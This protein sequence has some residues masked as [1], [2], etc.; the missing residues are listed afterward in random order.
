MSRSIAFPFLVLPDEAIKCSGWRIAAG[1]SEPRSCEATLE[2]WDYSTAIHAEI[3]ID[4][5][6]SAVTQCLCL[7][8]S[9]FELTAVVW[10]STGPGAL[11]LRHLGQRVSMKVGHSLNLGVKILGH[12]LSAKVRLELELFCSIEG[13][14]P[15]PLAP[16]LT[17]A[18]VWTCQSEVLLEGG[19]AS[20]F[21]L[22]ARSFREAFNNQPSRLAPWHL[23]WQSGVPDADFSSAVRLWVNAD[24]PQFMERFMAGDP[25]TVQAVLGDVKEQ[26]VAST[27]DSED[28][29]LDGDYGDGSVGAQVRYWI[30]SAFPGLDLDQ[31]R[32]LM[33]QDRG[34]FCSALLATAA[35]GEGT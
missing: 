2:G 18:R 31:I 8:Q 23:F 34:K 20:R 3:D 13:L 27:L 12:Q 25:L 14:S 35:Q 6:W 10:W 24:M 11:P 15:H 1:E 30:E 19:G 32:N 16:N 29:A 21:P 7:N 17:M 33:L 22:E 9:P 4:L 28:F 5:E 26:I